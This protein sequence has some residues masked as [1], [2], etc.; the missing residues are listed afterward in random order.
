MD[1]LVEALA[2]RV[3][4]QLGLSDLMTALQNGQKELQKHRGEIAAMLEGVADFLIQVERDDWGATISQ[5][6]TRIKKVLDDVRNAELIKD[7]AADAK[8]LVD[9][10]HIKSL[11]LRESAWAARGP[12]S[13]PGVNEILHLLERLSDVDDDDELALL[14]EYLEAKLEVEYA[15]LEQQSQMYQE[16]PE[17]LA[18]A[19]DELLPEYQELLGYVT[20]VFDLEEEELEQLFES[21]ENW[22]ANYSA[23]DLDF[24]SKRYSSV[25]T[26]LP[27][28]NFALNCQLLYLD[29]VVTE[30]MVDFAITQAADIIQNGSDVFL[31]EQTLS[32]VDLHGY[33]E[34]LD[35]LVN[36]LDG[37]PEIDDKPDLQEFGGELISL[38]SRFIDLQNRAETESGSRLDYKSDA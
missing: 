15:R 38:C 28:V 4:N 26:S 25:P 12:C 9:E 10:L 34:V 7:L 3:N 11:A 6:E 17:F 27:C 14:Q 29:E 21:L 35:D 13:H 32:D 37:I 31:K 19:M 33:N 8:K 23:F 5:L 16:L 36:G 18:T 20:N 24:L 2:A 1:A 22:G 30:E